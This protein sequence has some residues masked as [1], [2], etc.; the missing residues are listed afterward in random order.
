MRRILLGTAGLM[1]LV[2]PALAADIRAPV[3]KAPP[4]PVVPVW[5]W[6]G[7]YVGGHVG[8]L[9]ARQTED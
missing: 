5:S 4:P 6:T 2:S 9:W 7:C 1:A 8:G 3:Y